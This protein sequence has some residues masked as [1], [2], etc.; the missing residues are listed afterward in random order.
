[1][2]K[3]LSKAGTEEI[4]INILRATD[5]T[6]TANVVLNGELKVL[7]LRSGLREGRALSSL[8]LNVVLEVLAKPPDKKK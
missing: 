8:L 1:M 3:T 7:S 4:H 6:P 2:I 5:D